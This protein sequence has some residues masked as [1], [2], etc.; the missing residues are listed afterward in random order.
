MRERQ[1]DRSKQ[2]RERETDREKQ[3]QTNRETETNRQ[4]L[5][6]THTG[7]NTDELT[8][9]QAEN[10]HTRKVNHAVN[11]TLSGVS[12]ILMVTSRKQ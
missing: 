8:G 11:D 10:L 4:T 1:T 12:M 9:R 6:Q 2:A 3:R 7:K 5:A